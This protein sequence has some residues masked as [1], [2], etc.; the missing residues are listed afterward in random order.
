[1]S[2][3]LYRDGQLE[4]ARARAGELERYHPDFLPARLLQ[5]QINFDSGDPATAKRLA[6]EL[7]KRLSET[8]PSG[9]QTPQFLA[10]VK[11]N[12]LILR[13][14]AH[15][16]LGQAGAARADMEAAR[17]AGMRGVLVPT[18]ATR[19]EEVAAAPECAPTFAAAAGLLL[20]DR[21]RAATR[22]AA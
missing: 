8:A 3:A 16:R 4:Q 10:D 21:A 14:K 15:L 18:A 7:L 2:E 17:A 13:G 9:E 1:M 5:V 12:A 19:P 11:L 22:V 6:D 20:G